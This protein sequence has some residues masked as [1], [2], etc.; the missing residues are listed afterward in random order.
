MWDGTTLWAMDSGVPVITKDN[1]RSGVVL[2]V[3]EAVTPGASASPIAPTPAP[4]AA[5][6]PAEEGKLNGFAIFVVIGL[7]ILALVGVLAY[8]RS[9]KE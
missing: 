5:P 3:T 9:R 8:L 6:A 1:A 7:G 2:T 4:S